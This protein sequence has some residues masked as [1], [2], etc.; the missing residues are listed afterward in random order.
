MSE[1]R[2]LSKTGDS[3]SQRLVRGRLSTDA[4]SWGGAFNRYNPKYF[5]Y[6]FSCK[7]KKKPRGFS[8]ACI[9][10]SVGLM[11]KCTMKVWAEG[12]ENGLECPWW[13]FL[14]GHRWTD[15]QGS[16][17]VVFCSLLQ[18]FSRLRSLGI[19][20]SAPLHEHFYAHLDDEG[21]NPRFFFFFKKTNPHKNFCHLKREKHVL[22]KQT[23]VSTLYNAHHFFFCNLPVIISLSQPQGSLPFTLRV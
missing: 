7:K 4:W 15:F 20:Y 11:S 2:I 13:G 17:Q 5:G 6:L 16:W 22:E 14:N 12:S 18:L 10:A 23:S 9:E 3:V 19:L 8:S 1:L 21:S